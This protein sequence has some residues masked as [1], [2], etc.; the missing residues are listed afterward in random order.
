MKSASI[1][2]R[3]VQKESII[4]GKQKNYGEVVEFLDAHWRIHEKEK[5]LLIAKQLDKAFDTISQKVPTILISGI[6]GKSITTYF[7]GQLLQNEGLTVGAL[8]APHILTYNERFS[9]QGELIS[10][11][12]FTDLANE[13]INMAESIGVEAD[14]AAILMVMGLLY[15]KNAAI[16]VALIEVSEGGIADV[17]SICTPKVLAITRVSD[18]ETDQDL[19]ATKSLIENICGLV[20]KGTFVVS[21]DQNKANLHLMQDYTKANNG[22]W[23]MPIRKLA[24]LPY[25][26]QQIHGRCAS[27]AERIASFYVN[28]FQPQSAVESILTK[29]KGQRGRPTLE[30]KRISELNPKKTLEQFWKDVQNNLP[31]RFQLF[32]KEKPSVLLDNASNIDALKNILLGIRLLHYQRPLKGL[33]VVLGFNNIVNFDIEELLRLLRYFFKKTSGQVIIC[34]VQSIPGQKQDVLFDYEKLTND[35]KSMKIKARSAKNFKEAFD[36]AQSIV[37]ERHGLVVLTGS[38]SIVTE[39][40]KY[41]GIKKV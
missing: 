29:Q 22:S 9:L 13:V 10:N 21:G 2:K 12:T 14:T 8:Y 16:D 27:L 40:W 28:E 4:G 17:A 20:N 24:S 32:D 6:N 19:T 15:F 35:I 39:Y 30:A 38:T 23:V 25:L 41:R 7:T 31:G 34:P 26:F 5:S 11:K 1:Q 37:D 36:I 3:S 33:A 18:H